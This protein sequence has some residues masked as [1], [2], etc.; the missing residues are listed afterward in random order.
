VELVLVLVLVLVL[1]ERKA[2]NCRLREQALDQVLVRALGRV[3]V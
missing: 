3:L 1:T 2:E